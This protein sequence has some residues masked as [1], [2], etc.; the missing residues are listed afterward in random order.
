MLIFIGRPLR[1]LSRACRAVAPRALVVA[2]GAL[3]TAT[4]VDPAQAA[5]ARTRFKS[6]GSTTAQ[7]GRP[8]SMSG[9]EPVRLVVRLQS[10]SVAEVRARS[11]THT[12]SDQEESAVVATAHREHVAITPS[13]HSLGGKVVAEYHHAL[14]GVAVMIPRRQAAALA[15][16]PGVRSVHPVA[17]YRINNAVSIPFLDVPAVWQGHPSLKGE[18]VKIAIIDTGIDYTHANFGGPGTLAAWNAAVANSTQPAD[19]TLFGPHAPKVKGGIDLAGDNYNADDPT[20]VPV[21]DPNPLD[22]AAHGSHVSGTAAGFG[23]AGG[24]TYHGPYNAA[25]YTNTTF[26]IGPGVA[27]KADLYAVRVFGCAGSTNLVTDAID[28]AVQNHMDVISMS[29]GS[30]FGTPDDA[31]AVA[32]ANAIA[33]GISVVAASGNAGPGLYITSS[34]A[35]AD[36]VL[37]AAAMDARSVLTGGVILSLTDGTIDGLQGNSLPLPGGSVPVVVL[38]SGGVLSLG[39]SASDYPSGGTPGALVIVSRGNCTFSAKAD[40]AEAA[41]AAAI[42]VVNNRPDYFSPSFSDVPTIPFIALLQS[43]TPTIL[44]AGSTASMAAASIPNPDF[45]TLASFSSAGPRFG[46]SAFKP[47]VTAP[48]VGVISTAMG[49]GNQGVAFSGTSMATPHV[50]G[51]AALTR[52]AHPRW[53]PQAIEAAIVQTATPGLLTAPDPRMSGSGVVQPVGSTETQVVAQDDEGNASL[54]FGFEE[55]THDYS[56]T[57]ELT[58]RNLGRDRVR[59]S[60]SYSPAATATGVPH[61]I[62]LSRTSIAVDGHDSEDLRVSVHV[63]VATVGATHDNSGNQVYEDVAGYIVLS[64]TGGSS[65]P[66]LMVPYYLTTRAR[67]RLDASLQGN[68]SPHHPSA[69]LKLS[70]RGGG[71][72]GSADFYA[73]GLSSPSQGDPYFDTRAVG[74][75]SNILPGGADSF[76]VFAVNTYTRFSNAAIAEWDVLIDVNGDGQPDYVLFSGDHGY[77]IN[78]AFDGTVIDLLYD[79]NAGTITPLFYADVPTDGST[80][81]MPVYASQLGITPANPLFSYQVQYFDNTNGG[82]FAVPGAATFNAFSPSIS[83]ALYFTV[84]PGV[85]GTV[86]V[87]I[88]PTQWATSPALGLMIVSED[89]AS[90]PSQAVLLKAGGH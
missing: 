17:T 24:T 30:D 50:A 90:G 44:A 4:A 28:W 68:L 69:G 87:A 63:P 10:D 55:S 51:V 21:P 80:I 84:P 65:A 59:Y 61:T 86:P 43:D 46:D 89:N 3:I 25:A 82:A 57:R 18:G 62:N 33:A 2:L 71:I 12:L 49:T 23:V 45:E 32:E 20:S 16:L 13:I 15:Q 26:D 14:N 56:A 77:W 67:S 29:L 6:V 48:G 66:A 81:L 36:H 47:S 1:A 60:V 54:S 35:S 73:W 85:A 76:L 31:D 79:V 83:N 19:P 7:K 64:P 11:V 42:A 74:V 75:Q 58:I 52:E 5:D 70:N 8:L 37:S 9:N 53:S 72:T 34:P 27:P 22:C 41:G 38:A 88:D 78:G 39:C 40:N